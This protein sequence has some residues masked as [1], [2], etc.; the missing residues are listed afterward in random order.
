MSQRQAANTCAET[1]R[2]T[3]ASPA[4]SPQPL[5][6]VPRSA[7]HAS[8]AHRPAASPP[9]AP[10]RPRCRRRPS[11]AHDRGL[12]SSC[13]QRDVMRRAWRNVNG[14]TE[15]AGGAEQHQRLQ[16]R[17]LSRRRRA[18]PTRWDPPWCE[19]GTR[20]THVHAGGLQANC[21]DPRLSGDPTELDR[22]SGTVSRASA[23]PRLAPHLSH[24]RT[25]SH[26]RRSAAAVLCKPMRNI[27]CTALK[28]KVSTGTNA[29]TCADAV[30]AHELV[31]RKDLGELSLAAAAGQAAGRIS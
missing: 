13:G 2:P 17:Y 22:V 16:Q 29:I 21:L 25:T 30:R 7:P 1:R 5:A 26:K 23:A 10:R 24:R 14:Q 3:S 18:Y 8:L 9:S 6:P 4:S 27:S 11:A 28:W 31:Q 15:A 19:P 12:G 20:S